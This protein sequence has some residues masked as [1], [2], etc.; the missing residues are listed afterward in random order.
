LWQGDFID[1]A[2]HW[3]DRGVGFEGPLGDNVLHLSAGVGF[4]T[5]EKADAAWP[6]GAAKALGQRFRGYRLTK[7]DRPTFTYQVGAVK[8]EDFCK[9][10]VT[11]KDHTLRRTLTLTAD[12]GVDNLYFRAAVGNKIE[13]QPN[14]AYLVDGAYRIK[15]TANGSKVM[16]HKSGGKVELRVQVAFKDGKAVVVQDFTW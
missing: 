3:T 8:V 10:I 15:L 13:A 12:K 2:R 14:G 4:A 9:P 16:L 7:D 6:A 1:A 5:L 11:A